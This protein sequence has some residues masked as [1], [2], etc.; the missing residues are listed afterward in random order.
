ML[1]IGRF[2]D[3]FPLTGFGYSVSGGYASQY[4]SQFEQSLAMGMGQ[5]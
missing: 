3:S 1:L 2:P 5:V 4:I